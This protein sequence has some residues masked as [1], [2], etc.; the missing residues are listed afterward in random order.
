MSR[1]WSILKWLAEM[2]PFFLAFSA[3]FYAGY[4]K[5]DKASMHFFIILGAFFVVLREVYEIR[6]YLQ[7]LTEVEEIDEE[8]DEEAQAT[9]DEIPL[10]SSELQEIRTILERLI[11]D[12]NDDR[13]RHSGSTF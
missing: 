3:A 8:E 4:I 5:D 10:Q 13:G 7:M 11:E 1:L 2:F 12:E 6:K 9:T